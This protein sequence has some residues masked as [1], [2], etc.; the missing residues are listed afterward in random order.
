MVKQLVV[1]GWSGDRSIGQV[2]KTNTN[3]PPPIVQP[4]VV[5][6]VPRFLGVGYRAVIAAESAW[7]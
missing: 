1:V 7:A 5:G 4:L 3:L 6:Q 2:A